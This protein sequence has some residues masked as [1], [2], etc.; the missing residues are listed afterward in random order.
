MI[1]DLLKQF[2]MPSDVTKLAKVVDLVWD[3]RDS[4]GDVVRF[5]SENK[6]Q[7]TRSL[8]FVRDHGDELLDLAGRLPELLGHAGSGIEA[9]GAAAQ[10]ASR[11]LTGGDGGN[12]GADGLLDFASVALERCRSLVADAGALVGTIGARVEKLPLVDDA[13]A[14]LRASGERFDDL[15]SQLA[16]VAS[17]FTSLGQRLAEAGVDLDRAGSQLQVSG[18]ALRSFAGIAAPVAAMPR[19]FFS[20]PPP[21]VTV[22]AV[23]VVAVDERASAPAKKAP[24]KK[25]A[26]KKAAVKKAPVKKAAV[27]KAPVKKAAR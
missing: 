21:P 17:R 14:A 20:P 2:G 15:A 9:A 18:G 3:Q 26:V 27:K 13:A 24:A 19:A 23:D 10:T 22:V 7:L 5:V 11:F 12:V 1:D 4:L 6:E 16:E 8:G 25:A